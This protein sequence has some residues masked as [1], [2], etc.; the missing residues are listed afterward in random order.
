M[1]SLAADTR[2][3]IAI[4]H[5]DM[6]KGFDALAAIVEHTLKLDPLSDEEKG[7]GV[8]SSSLIAY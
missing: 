4:G 7:K 6:R 8:D 3:F 2:I 1:I 5:T